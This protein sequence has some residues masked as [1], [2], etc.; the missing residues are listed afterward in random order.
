[1]GISSR[2]VAL[3][4]FSVS[5][6]GVEIHTGWWRGRQVTYKVVE[7]MA[8]RQVDMVL[9]RAADIAESPP[10]PESP[11]SPDDATFAGSSA[12]LWPNGTVP[13]I[14]AS[15]VPSGLRQRIVA[16]IQVYT[17]S[18]PIRWIPRSSETN[19]V[20]FRDEPSIANEC[21]SSY[22]GRQGGM[23]DIVLNVDLTVCD[24]GS[25]IHEMGHT[26]GFEHEQTRAN[27]DYYIRIR[28]ENIDKNAWDEYDR[29][30]G[31]QVDLLPYE[32]GS[33]MHYGAYDFQRNNFNTI[34]TLPLGIPI[35]RATALSAG[36]LEAVRTMYGQPSAATTVATNP[37]GLQVLVDGVLLTSPR[38]FN[39]APGSRHTLNTP[40]GPQAQD[41]GTR[42]VFARWSND[43]GQAQTITA[44]RAN[45]LITANFSTQYRLQTA[46]GSGGGGSVGVNPSAPD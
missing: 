7:G 45:R 44:S 2:I 21:G 23:Q 31:G 22:V 39:W 41:S 1:M 8:I 3:T 30:P 26:I 5:V 11:K 16:A 12:F 19:Y 35:S 42:Y 17:D 29:A 14:I 43:G 27:R 32:Y 4:L 40:A 46:V 25:A 15:T 34:D 20:R 24:A 10:L 33:I 13:Y 6:R 9:G 37:P 18:T 38:T 28:Y 36:D